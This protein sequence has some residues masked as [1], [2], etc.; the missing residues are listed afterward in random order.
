MLRTLYRRH[1]NLV[2]LV[3]YLVQIYKV[4]KLPDSVLRISDSII[5]R[6]HEAAEMWL[7]GLLHTDVTYISEPRSLSL[8]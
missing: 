7:W 1:N 3:S 6:P 4:L 8:F 5:E 2:Y